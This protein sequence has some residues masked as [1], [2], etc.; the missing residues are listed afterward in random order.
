MTGDLF[1]IYKDFTETMRMSE[2]V[3][4]R[5]V[6]IDRADEAADDLWKTSARSALRRACLSLDEFT[7]DDLWGSLERPR[8]P[9]AI[10]GVMRFGVSKGWCEATDRTRRSADATCHARPKRIWRSLLR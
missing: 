4:A 3:R 6:A 7:T 8:E 9:R 1:S 10:A 5:D 2:A